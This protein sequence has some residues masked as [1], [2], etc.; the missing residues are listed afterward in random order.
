MELGLR[1][2]VAWITGAASGLGL[3]TGRYLAREGAR[4]LLADVDHERLGKAAEEL[5]GMGAQTE[6]LPLDVRDFAAC[7]AAAA[8]AHERFGALDV[9]VASA[10]VADE[11]FFLE[12]RPGDWDRMLDTN[13]RGVLN[14]NHAAARLMVE[15][16]RGSIV[17]LA[18]EAG[19]VG[20]KRMVVYAATKG[21]VIAFSKAFAV[22]MGRFGV[23]VNAVCPGVT[24]TPMTAAYTP[25]QRERAA[26]LYPLGRLGEPADVASMIT[27]LASDEAAW[28]TG[29]AL[30]VNGGFG[31]S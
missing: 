1:G 18:S 21:A 24:R 10:G 12:T 29:Q 26:R 5:A 30:S 31:R 6:A 13:L 3:E 20:E 8:R 25:E 15:Q 19:K 14:T 9:L 16:R 7:E 2:R 4:L 22:E 23:R 28:V 17:N 27:F 11:R